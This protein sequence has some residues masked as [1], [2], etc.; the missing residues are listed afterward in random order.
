MGSED[1]VIQMTLTEAQKFLRLVTHAIIVGIN[2]LE[3]DAVASLMVAR[4]VVDKDP[5]QG[6]FTFS[7]LTLYF[8]VET[9]VMVPDQISDYQFKTDTNQL[10]LT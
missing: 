1:T 6:T 2:N 5:A 9:K 3:P 10:K 4:D 7:D 8:L